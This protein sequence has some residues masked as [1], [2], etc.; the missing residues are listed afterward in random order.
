VTHKRTTPTCSEQLQV[1]A[2]TPLRK[3]GKTRRRRLIRALLAFHEAAHAA[4][5][6]LLGE[7]IN[8]ATI[9]AKGEAA[10]HVAF[11]F[12]ADKNRVTTLLAGRVAES[13]CGLRV[14]CGDSEE[15]DIAS[16]WSLYEGLNSTGGVDGPFQNHVEKV[17]ALLIGHWSLIEL[18]AE[19]L[20]RLV[21][22]YGETL[23]TVFRAWK[24]GRRSVDAR[25]LG[26]LRRHQ[27]ASRAWRRQQKEELRGWR[28]SEER[29]AKRAQVAP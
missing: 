16:A 18:I 20:K 22:V 2:S 6:L 17:G 9:R 26:R 1:F 13:A 12:D 24:L 23:E 25:F 14:C 21:H 27:A 4:V 3:I 28:R 7:D 5:A 10:G 29:R 15:D 11:F 8:Y 19:V